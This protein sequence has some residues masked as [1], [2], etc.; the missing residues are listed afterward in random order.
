MKELRTALKQLT[1]GTEQLSEGSKQ[2]ADGMKT[3]HETG[4]NKICNY[5]NGDVKDVA[6][7]AEKLQDLSK[8]Y[9]NFSKTADNNDVA[10]GDINFVY[11]TDGAK[12]DNDNDDNS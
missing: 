8:N 10:V 6:T 4:I 7:R 12:K 11:I 5:I 3:F 9:K 2:L 1:N